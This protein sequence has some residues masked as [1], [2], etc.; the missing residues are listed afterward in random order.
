MTK[1]ALIFLLVIL[2][3]FSLILSLPF[4]LANA[5]KSPDYPTIEEV[6]MNISYGGRAVAASVNP[7]NSAIAL[8]A[9]ESGGL[10]RTTNSGVTWE[11]VD[12]LPLIHLND[13]HYA[14]WPNQNVVLAAG[15]SDG[16]LPDDTGGIWR[17]N[18]GGVNWYKP[19]TS[20][21]GCR[22]MA[23]AWSFAFGGSSGWT[24]A[25]TSCGL[26]VSGDWG[27]S[28]PV[29]YTIGSEHMY[30]AVAAD[31]NNFYVCNDQG[32][33]RGTGSVLGG[34]V[35]TAH[36]CGWSRHNLAISPLESNVVY[37]IDSS[38]ILPPGCVGDD[39][40]GRALYEGI[41]NSSTDQVTWTRVF[42]T[43]FRTGGRFPWV[44]TNLSRDG[45]SNHYDLYFG[46]GLKTFRNTCTSGGTGT[47]CPATGWQQ[48]QEDHDDQNNLVFD[49][50]TRCAKYLLSDGGIHG[51]VDAGNQ[52]TCGSRFSVIGTPL[53]G[54][55][56]LQVYQL[57]GTNM[58][59]G[60]L[61]PHTDL[62]AGT[63]DNSFWASEDGGATW[64][65]GCGNEGYH[66]EVPLTGTNHA[67]QWIPVTY[68]DAGSHANWATAAHFEG[69][70]GTECQGM[71]VQNPTGAILEPPLLLNVSN[72]LTGGAWYLQYSEPVTHSRNYQLNLGHSVPSFTPSYR[73]A[74]TWSAVNQTTY[75]LEDRAQ[76]STSGEHITYYRP[77]RKPATWTNRNDLHQGL[78]KVTGIHSDGTLD[79]SPPT[80]LANGSGDNLLG[81]LSIY[82]PGD[83]AWWYPTVYGVDP[84]N[85]NH[86]I[87]ADIVSETMKVSLDGGLNW[88]TDANLTALVTNNGEYH[89]V[90]H[91]D[92]VPAGP[93]G[94]TIQAHAIGFDPFVRNHILVGTHNLGI[95]QS[96]NGG[97]SWD[98]IPGTE[99]ITNITDFFFMKWPPPV[100]NV[101][102]FWV[103]TYGR[104]IWKVS[105]AIPAFLYRYNDGLVAKL[106]SLVLDPNTGA[107]I[108]PSIITDSTVCPQ[109]QFLVVPRGEIWGLDTSGNLV[110][111]LHLYDKLGGH[112][113]GSNN[114]GEPLNS[115]I[116]VDYTASMGTF[117]DCKY[118][119]DVYAAG[120]RIRG[121]VIN[122]AA[123]VSRPGAPDTSELVAIITS[124][125]SSDL[126]GASQIE[127]FDAFPPEGPLGPDATPITDP[128]IQLE[129]KYAVGGQA[130]IGNGD[131]LF[132]MGTGFSGDT[133]TCGYVHILIDDEEIAGVTPYSD[134]SFSSELP[135][136]VDRP[137][138]H[139]LRAEQP[140]NSDTLMDWAS[141]MV[142]IEEEWWDY[143]YL[144]LPLIRR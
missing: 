55:N 62:Y 45:V 114:V 87:A 122:K 50:S 19:D 130:T 59:S 65:H 115:D 140:C 13:V 107:A 85:P 71:D 125:G 63:Q 109:C 133:E 21:P 84:R 39:K 17:S 128:Y 103:A 57:A 101:T 134:G 116:P 3:S 27:Y 69:P 96:F 144:Y 106:Q 82:A 129:G 117:T 20:H 36:G 2:A 58:S 35:S 12:A 8:V 75:S 76:I 34:F 139:E 143:R 142:V 15:W 78:I 22:A 32:L 92:E 90:V 48:V 53:N 24:Y 37:M 46:N 131:K 47:R 25:A 44:V 94:I 52:A 18:D 124:E 112:L 113:V 41:Y 56:A 89:F 97:E 95:I 5:G 120:N 111:G 72:S 99:K 66:I 38:G 86:L 98:V 126:P 54:Y 93:Y 6:H 81:A 60:T 118:C 127:K 33:R 31:A 61:G 10:F 136:T 102:T 64:P 73:Y 121:I 135:V 43:C 91:S 26:S 51:A 9:S 137:G 79:P 70:T 11:H 23:D 42:N 123:L 119:D 28:W 110:T 68:H 49:P 7:A 83:A 100:H 40:E 108:D 4:A 132:V 105:D 138:H 1:R 104:G 30:F 88:I 29:T 74:W 80:T 67:S 141:F 14:P 77:Y 16:H